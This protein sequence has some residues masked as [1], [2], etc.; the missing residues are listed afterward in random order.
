MMAQPDKE[1][2]KKLKNGGLKAFEVIFS[3]YEKSIYGYIYSMVGHRENA[4]DLTQEVFLKLYKNAG[5][6]DA[7]NNF[8]NWLYKIATNTVYDWLRKKRKGAEMFII[9]DEENSFETIDDNSTYLHI[10]DAKDLESAI[11]DIKPNYRRVL[12]LFYYEGMSYEE[13]ADI[14][15][16]PLNTA[17][18][19]IRRAKEALKMVYDKKGV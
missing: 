13:I 17:K 15:E 16:V 7:E 8:K 18:T 6:I 1:T 3:F 12:L 4:E 19:H 14:L 9:D 5:A 10:E 2:L 11:N